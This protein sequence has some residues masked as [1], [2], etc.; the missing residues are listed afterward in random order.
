MSRGD[1]RRSK[2]E[3]A[4]QLGYADGRERKAHARYRSTTLQWA[5]DLGYGRGR[6]DRLA[7]IKRPEGDT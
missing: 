5:Y 2:L 1:R 3:T 6:M 7:L 4:R